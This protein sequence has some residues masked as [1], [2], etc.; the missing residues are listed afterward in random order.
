MRRFRLLLVTGLLL[1]SCSGLPNEP[2]PLRFGS[3]SETC[4]LPG[5]QISSGDYVNRDAAAR[6][7]VLAPLNKTSG[8]DQNSS[9]QPRRV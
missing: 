8:S 5:L 6:F 9:G 3:S 7:D 1:S 2:T 4:H